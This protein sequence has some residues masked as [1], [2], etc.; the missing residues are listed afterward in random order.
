[1]V[2]M[3]YLNVPLGFVDLSL[4]GQ[5]VL[6]GQLPLLLQLE[7]QVIQLLQT[8]HTQMWIFNILYNSGKENT[9]CSCLPL[10]ANSW[11]PAEHKSWTAT[12]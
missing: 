7:L 11:D 4:Q 3:T 12:L 9:L 2:L 5:L 10:C 6:Q 1:M 8:Q